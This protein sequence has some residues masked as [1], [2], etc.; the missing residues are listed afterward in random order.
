MWTHKVVLNWHGELH[1]FYTN[2]S[3]DIGALMNAQ[4]QLAKKLH[5]TFYKVR[6]HFNQGSPNYNI[7]RI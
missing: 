5:I 3:N 6:Q 2:S 4:F 1:T 7:E